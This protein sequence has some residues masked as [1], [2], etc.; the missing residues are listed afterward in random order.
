MSPCTSACRHTP[1]PTAES[2]IRLATD[3][4]RDFVLALKN[5]S[6]A[7]Q[8]STTKRSVTPAEHCAWW[9][10]TQD[11]RWILEAER[12]RLGYLR[13]SPAGVISINVKDS[14][15]G[16]GYGGQLV[17]YATTFGKGM[18][19]YRLTAFVDLEN[20]PSWRAFRRDGFKAVAIAPMLEELRLEKGLR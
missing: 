3:V 10:S 17:R 5:E 13:I 7:V 19:L 6:V 8:Y 18:G 1:I 2:S 14:E 11:H 4:D 9:D 12:G 20:V 15:R 16:K